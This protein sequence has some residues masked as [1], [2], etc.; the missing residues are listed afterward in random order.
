MEY[1]TIRSVELARVFGKL[2]AAFC[3]GVHLIK[4]EEEVQL[5][6]CCDD[7]LGTLPDKL[8]N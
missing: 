6:K 8:E 1:D 3:C 7:F 5:L 2:V 4:C